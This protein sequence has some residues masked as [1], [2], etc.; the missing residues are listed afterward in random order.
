MHT[1]MVAEKDAVFWAENDAVSLA[2]T[3]AA[4]I[5]LYE[6]SS[7]KQTCLARRMSM[8]GTENWITV[9]AEYP[10]AFE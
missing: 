6:R 10:V 7:N 9:L 4:S 3:A 5:E 1:A 2:A 8:K